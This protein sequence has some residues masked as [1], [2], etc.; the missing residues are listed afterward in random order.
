MQASVTSSDGATAE[1]T[2]K[3]ARRATARITY[4][5]EVNGDARVERWSQ[6]G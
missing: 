6:S 1:T 4:D 5:P 3:H 2:L